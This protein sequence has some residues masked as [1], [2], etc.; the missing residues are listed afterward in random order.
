MLKKPG[1]TRSRGG[2]RRG[3]FNQ[4]PSVS[5]TPPPAV[6]RQS[7]IERRRATERRRSHEIRQALHQEFHNLE[8]VEVYSGVVAKSIIFVAPFPYAIDPDNPKTLNAPTRDEV[9]RQGRA[10]YNDGHLELWF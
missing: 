10:V 6:D 9:M 3:R 5:C 1:F 2:D 8:G 7:A 4:P